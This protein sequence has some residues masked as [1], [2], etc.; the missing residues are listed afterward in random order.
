MSS[1]W[2]CPECGR[3]CAATESWCK[4]CSTTRPLDMKTPYARDRARRVLA[5]FAHCF[6][7]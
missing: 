5:R 4:L 6:E 1:P 3:L 7:Q 2:R